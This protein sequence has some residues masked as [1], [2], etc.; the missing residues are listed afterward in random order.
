MICTAPTIN[1]IVT[2]MMNSL[3]YSVGTTTRVP[4]QDRNMTLFVKSEDERALFK[5]TPSVNTSLA[6]GNHVIFEDNCTLNIIV[7]N[8]GKFNYE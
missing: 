7:I 5:V 1:N 6:V 8:N 2:Q 3:F 4:C